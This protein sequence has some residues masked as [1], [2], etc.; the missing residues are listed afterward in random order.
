MARA[1]SRF[2][3]Y[4]RTISNAAVS[5]FDAEDDPEKRFHYYALTITNSE[6]AAIEAEIRKAEEQLES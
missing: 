2:D 3:L 4:S 5:E 1:Q 6:Q